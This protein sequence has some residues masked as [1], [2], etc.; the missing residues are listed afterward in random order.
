VP[1]VSAW[2]REAGRA[3]CAVVTATALLG[4]PGARR[5]GAVSMRFRVTLRG[6]AGGCRECGSSGEQV[7]IVGERTDTRRR[8]RIRWCDVHVEASGCRD[9]REAVDGTWGCAGCDAEQ[10][11][12]ERSDPRRLWRISF[13]GGG[14][15]PSLV[16]LSKEGRSLRV[17]W[18]EHCRSPRWTV[19]RRCTRM[20][21]PGYDRG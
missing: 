17:G 9:A 18:P 1:A 4:A 2:R 15:G 12:T 7:E 21:C 11:A 10:R 8:M 20:C 5:L 6:G 19:R 16:T 13:A 14:A 3:G